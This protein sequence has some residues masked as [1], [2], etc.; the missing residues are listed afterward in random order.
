MLAVRDAITTNSRNAQQKFAELACGKFETQGVTKAA[1]A[2][3][4]F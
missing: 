2:G 1:M 3:I 4:V